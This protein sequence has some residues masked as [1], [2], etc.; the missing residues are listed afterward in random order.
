[1]N[2]SQKKLSHVWLISPWL[3]K[4]VLR[5]RLKHVLK[6]IKKEDAALKREGLENLREEQLKAVSIIKK[7]CHCSCADSLFCARKCNSHCSSCCESHFS[8]CVYA[9]LLGLW[10]LWLFK[11]PEKD[12]NDGSFVKGHTMLKCIWSEFFFC[13]ILPSNI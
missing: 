8:L 9:K 7:H 12:K 11:N 4:P 3:P 10:K 13:I 2:I 1:M 6:S 5:A